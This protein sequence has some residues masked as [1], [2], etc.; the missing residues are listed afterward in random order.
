MELVSNLVG[1]VVLLTADGPWDG[2]FNGEWWWWVLR[3]LTFVLTILF[4]A[5]IIRFVIF[6]AFRPLG[7]FGGPGRGGRDRDR[8]RDADDDQPRAETPGV[9]R[10]RDILTERYAR[11]E[12]DGEEYRGRLDQLR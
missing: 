7:G 10:A 5:F 6:G 11:S 12:I 4:V 2:D 3:P 8:D 1:N 9:A